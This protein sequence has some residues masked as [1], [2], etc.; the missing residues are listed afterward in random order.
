V[1]NDVLPGIGVRWVAERI[2]INDGEAFDLRAS[3][4]PGEFSEGG[5]RQRSIVDLDLPGD[6]VIGLAQLVGVDLAGAVGTA[7]KFAGCV[8]P[9]AL[10]F[11]RRS[12]T[13]STEPRGKLDARHVITAAL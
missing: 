5:A 8:L 1:D 9:H 11:V 4:Q 3:R 10:I 6:R 12:E 13:S 7:G 2:E